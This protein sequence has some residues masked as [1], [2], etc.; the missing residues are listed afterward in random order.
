M[1]WSEWQTGVLE[2]R[3]CE[4]E[5]EPPDWLAGLQP[6]KNHCPFWWAQTARDRCP[7]SVHLLDRN[8]RHKTLAKKPRR[9]QSDASDQGS[10]R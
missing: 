2:A 9:T 3:D 1:G 4:A 8:S 6:V 7:L 10:S 5:V